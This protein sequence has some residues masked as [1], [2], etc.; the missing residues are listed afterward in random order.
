MDPL[1]YAGGHDLD[2]QLA[3]KDKPSHPPPGHR[4]CEA[5]SAGFRTCTGRRSN[6]WPAR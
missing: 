4:L 2:R 1:L 3:D 6:G 5:S